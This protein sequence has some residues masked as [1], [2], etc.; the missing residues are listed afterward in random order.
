M[1]ELGRIADDRRA[2]GLHRDLL[3]RPPSGAVA[4]G[5]AAPLDLA[6]NDYLG[7]HDDPRVV[8]AAVPVVLGDPERAVAAR[9]N[10]LARGVLVGVF[11]PP[12][13]PPGGSRLRLTAR[14]NLTP[15]ELEM[16]APRPGD[17]PGE[18]EGSG[19]GPAGLSGGRA[20]VRVAG[21]T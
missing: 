17:V 18:Q 6:A 20:A 2:R 4:G 16:A 7:L 12:S 19:P 15:A 21:C 10:L 8:D 14:A 13:V 11:R 9:D 3:V 5:E 1:G